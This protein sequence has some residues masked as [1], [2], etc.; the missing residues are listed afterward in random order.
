MTPPARLA[1]LYG[2]VFA[3]PGVAMPFLPPWLAAGGLGPEAIGT[4]LALPIL[5]RIGLVAP[6]MGLVDRGAS[7]RMLIVL[8]GLLAALSY[9]LMPAALGAGAGFV[10]VVL[11]LN[12][13]AQCVLVPT[14]DYLTLAAV[15]RAPHLDYARIR[16]WG[17]LTFL[18]ANLLAG[19]ILSRSN[20]ADAVVWILAGLSL[21]VVAAGSGMGTG[22]SGPRPPPGAPRPARPPLPRA[23]WLALLAAALVQASHAAVYGFSSIHWRAEGLSDAAIGLLWAVGVAA[24]ILL[25][26][27]YGLSARGLG[28][29]FALIGIGALAGIARWSL[30]PLVPSSLPV[31]VALQALHGLTFGATHL[32]TM[33]AV[34]ALAPPAAR[35]RAQGLVTTVA[36]LGMAGATFA[37]GAA[38]REFGAAP[39]FLLM[40]PL[41]AAGLVLAMLGARQRG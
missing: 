29:P 24:E 16:I 41:A 22:A 35:G 38:Y 11:V 36:S 26:A 30:L 2:T 33:A 20:A 10:A 1:A 13:V 7:P 34:S 40:A 15:R 5:V 28:R 39:T 37:S 21:A 19:A 23:L 4:L 12:A 6:L 17:S 9:A 18:A 3:V 14:A 8:G 27:V 25:F 31:L 32:G